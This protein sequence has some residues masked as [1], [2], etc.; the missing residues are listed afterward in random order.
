[1]RVRLS[2]Y[3]GTIELTTPTVVEKPEYVLIIAGAGLASN[4]I[5]GT[6]LG[7]HEHNHGET[8]AVQ[9]DLE[10]LRPH[11]DLG[12]RHKIE[13]EEQGWWAKATKIISHGHDHD[14][15]VHDNSANSETDHGHQNHDLGMQAVFIH[16]MG[17]AAN[18]IGVAAAAIGMLQAKSPKRFY[19][20]P[21]VSMVIGIV[22]MVMA[23]SLG[24]FHLIQE[25]CK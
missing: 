24:K 14:E 13:P 23:L 3:L 25:V 9:L 6:F 19:A 22:L 16:V 5:S 15:D 2:I 20:D 17:D 11:Q 4:I 18:N 1:M 10:S 8:S 21:A 12:H 7:V